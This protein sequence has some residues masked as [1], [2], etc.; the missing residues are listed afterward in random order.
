MIINDPKTLVLAYHNAFYRNDREAVRK[1]L[2]DNGIFMGPLNS[3][4]DADTFLDSAG[5]FMQLAKTTE[6]K[7]IFTDGNDVCVLYNSTTIVPSIPVL[8]IASW[9]RVESGKINFFH[10]HFDPSPFVKAKEN[11]DIAKVLQASK[12]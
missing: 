5:I 4:T 2:M 12:I 8:P 1:L 9:F 11:G 7:K 3:F 6:I 10:V